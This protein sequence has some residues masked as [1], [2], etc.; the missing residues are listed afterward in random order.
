MDIHIDWLSFTLP[1]PREPHTSHD[2]LELSRMVLNGKQKSLATEIYKGHDWQV[3]TSRPPY[4]IAILRDDHAY[5][6][7]GHSHTNT[8]LFEI[9]G[10]GSEALRS[11]QMASNVLAA[12]GE[13]ITRID[14]AGD[15]RTHLRPVDILSERSHNRMRSQSTITSDTGETCY[16]GSAKSD[17]FVRVYRYNA[18]H[19]RSD[20]IRCEFVY[21]REYARV[22]AAELGATYDIRE[23]FARSINSFG[24]SHPILNPGV[25]TSERVSVKM[26]SRQDEQTVRWLYAQVAPA[27]RRLVGSGALDLGEWLAYIYGVSDETDPIGKMDVAQ[28][29]AKSIGW[30]VDAAKQ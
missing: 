30:I 1:A 10:R 24:L 14:I 25:E 3:T 2:L 19:P 16:L 12:I 17:R 28:L 11:S 7:Y 6:I 4:K 21:R 22:A 9:T 20:F 8:I 26:A 18:P 23:F 5:S 29:D 27:V 15:V 13:H